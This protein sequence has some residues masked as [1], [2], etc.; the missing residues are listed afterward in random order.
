MTW[1]KPVTIDYVDDV[2]GEEFWVY[3]QIRIVVDALYDAC[4]DLHKIGEFLFSSALFIPL[5]SGA[6]L[7]VWDPE[8]GVPDFR[9]PVRKYTH[10][11]LVML[12][13]IVL[14]ESR[15]PKFM[16]NPQFIPWLVQLTSIPG[17]EDTM[18]FKDY[19]GVNR[20]GK[21]CTPPR[22]YSWLQDVAWVS[23]IV[24]IIVIIK[25]FGLIKL[26]RRFI[27]R[28]FGWRQRW[29]IGEIYDNTKDIYDQIEDLQYAIDENNVDEAIET[30]IAQVESLRASVGDRKS[31]V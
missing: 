5:P 1:Q 11:R 23:L 3:T 27:V 15:I 29:M 18:Y 13:G 24:A 25:R 19:D 21:D 28:V 22:Q 20:L 14:F 30:L 26:L 8:V 31:V 12:D 2:E 4:C 10:W 9:L 6:A 16:A 17:S 7:K